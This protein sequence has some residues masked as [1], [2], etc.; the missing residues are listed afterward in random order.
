MKLRLNQIRQIK[1]T[2]S[3]RIKDLIQKN[4]QDESELYL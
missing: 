4:F 3:N 2:H 1:F